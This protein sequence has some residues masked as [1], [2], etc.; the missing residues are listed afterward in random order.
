[1]KKIIYPF[2][3]LLHRVIFF[4]FLFVSKTFY[5]RK[6]IRTGHISSEHLKNPVL[7]DK[8]SEELKQLGVEVNELKISREEYLKYLSKASYAEN[9]YGGGK[10]PEMNFTE[11]TLEHFVSTLFIDFYPEMTFIDYAAATSPFSSIIKNIFGISHSFCQDII[12]EKG[13]HGNKIGG[14]PSDFQLPDNSVDAVTLHCSLE[15]FEGESDIDFFRSMEK[16]LKPGGRII[17]LPFYLAYEYT[18]HLDPA[19]NLLKFH[20]PETDHQARIRYCNWKQF[21]S[22]HYSP[23][24]LYDR[25]L[26]NCPGLKLT[27]Y[28]VLN[29]REIDEHCYLRFVG[30]F[31]KR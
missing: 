8:L 22:R 6:N 7:D 28:R 5:R 14:Y 16:M 20:S 17:V 3:N 21:F 9:Y 2:Y 23:Q 4:L 15:H 25:I 27:V 30:V 24:I 11:K 12:F 1:M 18:I 29:F 19:Y 31:T 13:I 26:S 10:N